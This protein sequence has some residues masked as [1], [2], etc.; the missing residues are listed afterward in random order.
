MAGD[1]CSQRSGHQGSEVQGEEW[2]GERGAVG[3]ERERMG[4]ARADATHQEGQDP[5]RSKDKG[6]RD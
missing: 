2:E 6:T 5:V 4:S 1:I 3:R